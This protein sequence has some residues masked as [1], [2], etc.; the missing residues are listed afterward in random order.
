MSDTPWETR[1]VTTHPLQAT[2]GRC[3]AI[4][5]ALAV[6]MA[7]RA[8]VT[9]PPELDMELGVT[10]AL[11]LTRSAIAPSGMIP[12]P[13]AGGVAL[14]TTIIP[15]APRT[16]TPLPESGPRLPPLSGTRMM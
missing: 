13:S 9:D 11:D 12:A 14:L 7:G 10:V 3:G 5:G 16:P 4:G 8:K 6:G 15:S 1:A 2:Q